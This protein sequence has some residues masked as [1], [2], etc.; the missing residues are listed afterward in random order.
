ITQSHSFAVQR[1]GFEVRGAFARPRPGETAPVQLV[2]QL[3]GKVFVVVTAESQHLCLLLIYS[4]AFPVRCRQPPCRLLC[5]LPGPLTLL[6][7]SERSYN[8]F[9]AS[10]R[11]F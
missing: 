7:S 9:I 3:T 6:L 10:S 5:P 11:A 4:R 2:H 1:S 8:A